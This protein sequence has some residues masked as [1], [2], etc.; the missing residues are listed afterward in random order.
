MIKRIVDFSFSLF[1]IILLLPLFI[2]VAI[3]ITLDSR[4]GVFYLQTRVGKNNKDFKLFKFRTMRT[5]ADKKG[6]LTVGSADNRITKTGLWLRKYKMDELPQLFNVLIGNMSLVGPRPEV[7]KYVELYSPEQLNVLSVKPGITDYASI[8][9][10]DENELLSKQAEPEKFY[11]AEVMPS[12]LK[13]N[14][15]YIANQ[16]VIEDFRIILKTFNK[17]FTK[18]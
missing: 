15:K 2:I 17:I 18:R 9:Y 13:I 14:L 11:I 3:L 12:K 5:G 4:G 6:L 8:E 1:G 16:S 10:A 7:R